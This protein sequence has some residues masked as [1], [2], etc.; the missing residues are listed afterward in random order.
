MNKI[1]QT[2]LIEVKGLKKYFKKNGKPFM[3]LTILT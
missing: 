1:E 2:P 3:P